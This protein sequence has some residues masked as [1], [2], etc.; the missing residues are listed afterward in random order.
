MDDRRW[1]HDV[2]PEPIDWLI[3]GY[4]AKGIVSIIA[5]PRSA[6]KSLAAIWLA[7][8]VSAGGSL[9]EGIRYSVWLNSLEDD[10]AAVIRPRLDVAGADLSRIELTDYEWRLPVDLPV[11]R[12]MLKA[13]RTDLLILDSVQQ[14]VPGLSSQPRAQEAMRG[15]V[16]LAQD[17]EMAVLLVGHTVKSSG[18]SVQAAIGGAGV[19]Q[20]LA[21]AIYVLG[22]AGP[23]RIDARALFQRMIQGPAS[24]SVE[25]LEDPG[26]DLRVLACER[27][28]IAPIPPSLLFRLQTKFHAATNAEAAYLVAEGTS[29]HSATDVLRAIHEAAHGSTDNAAETKVI[30]AAS[31]LYETLATNGPMTTARLIRQAKKD[32]AYHS[33]NTFDRARK[34]AGVRSV[35]PSQ[36][37]DFVGAERYEQLPEDERKSWWAYIPPVGEPPVDEWQDEGD[38]P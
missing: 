33:R 23:A 20:N 6:G 17:F 4:F 1:A 9:T 26:E 29:D 38:G 32:G 30:E 18:R 10:L 15:L 34:V 36:L 14:H 11:I 35:R 22:P 8:E 28:G 2:R 31:W 27:F 16:R 5:S 13:R 37:R 7:T 12:S 19:I 25:P 24:E 3:E 21:K